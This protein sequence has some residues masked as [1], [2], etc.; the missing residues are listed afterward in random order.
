MNVFQV[1]QSNLD[2]GFILSCEVFLQFADLGKPDALFKNITQLEFHIKLILHFFLFHIIFY[3]YTYRNFH[4]FTIHCG[5]HPYS[6][7][8][9]LAQFWNEKHIFLGISRF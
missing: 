3:I 6:H 8:C 1:Q 9:S 5:I 4:I 2:N 7:I